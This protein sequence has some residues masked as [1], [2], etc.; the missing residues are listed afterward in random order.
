MWWQ[1]DDPAEPADVRAVL[2]RFDRA[3]ARCGTVRVLAIDGRS[4]SGKTTLAR[5]VHHGLVGD[6][7]ARV[8]MIHLDELYP[9]WDGLAETVAL[10]HD[11][12]LE[13][14]S[15][16]A[17]A[18]YRHWDWSA[19]QWGPVRRLDPP[20]VLIVEGCGA[21][22]RP[23]GDLAALR[24]WLEA[25]AAERLARGVARDG[26]QL[27]ANWARWSHQED[28]LFTADRTRERADLLVSTSPPLPRPQ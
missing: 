15:R 5:G 17:T 28:A 2:E 27:R 10:L 1:V 20:S 22:V 16:G 19:D 13:P 8:A 18:T 26:E 12:I 25:P 11:Q 9:G 21:A 4:G 24:V 3:P 14:L 23:P 6:G 7:S